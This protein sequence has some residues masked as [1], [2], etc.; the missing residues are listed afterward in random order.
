MNRAVKYAVYAAAF[1]ISLAAA[2]Y[3]TTHVIVRGRPEVMVPDLVGLSEVGALKSLADLGLELKVEDRVHSADAPEGRVLSQEP[4]AGRRIKRGREIEVMVSS[5]PAQVDLPDLAG[6]SLDQ[7]R[8]ILEQNRLKTGVVAHAHGGVRVRDRVMAQSPLPP[9]RVRVGSSV[10]LLV[11]LGP[12]PR[13]VVMPDLTGLSYAAAVNLIRRSGLVLGR[14]A[15]ETRRTW[16][17]ETVLLQEPEA[18]ARAERGERVRL[19][20]NRID[21][22][23]LRPPRL[24]LIDYRVSLGLTPREVTVQVWRDGRFDRV[25]QRTHRPGERILVPILADPSARV[26]I[27]ENGREV[28]FSSESI[29]RSD[30]NDQNRPFHSFGRL[31]SAG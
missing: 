17:A 16:P 8:L 19:T 15:G 30:I 6:L 20:V 13:W 29:Y 22:A 24:A 3:G 25:Y 10:S 9:A 7:A 11:S 14:V 27:R 21:P 26:R 2:G 4:A 23:E 18:G 12:P 1:L 31:R 28:D 5:G